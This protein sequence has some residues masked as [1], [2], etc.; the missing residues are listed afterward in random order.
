MCELL[1]YDKYEADEVEAIEAE[2]AEIALKRAFSEER[3]IDL[4]KSGEA[5]ARRFVS[6]CVGN[7]PA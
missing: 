1:G 6:D 7:R 4:A 2:A 3:R 5:M